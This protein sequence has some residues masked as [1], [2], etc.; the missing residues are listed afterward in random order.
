MFKKSKKRNCQ[1]FITVIGLILI[2]LLELVGSIFLFPIKETQ[3]EGWLSGYSY[4]KAITITGETGAGTNYQVKLLVGESSGAT[5][6]DFDIENNDAAWPNDIRF[7]DNDGFTQLDYWL[8]SDIDSESNRLA[9]FWVEVADDL[10]SNVDIYVYYGK[11]GDSDESNGDNTFLFFDDFPG[12]SID[13]AKW[14][15]VNNGGSITVA[16]SIVDI[17][18]SAADKDNAEIISQNAFA[19]GNMMETYAKITG[20]TNDYHQ[21]GRGSDFTTGGFG[22]EKPAVNYLYQYRYTYDEPDI[23]NRIDSMKDSAGTSSNTDIPLVTWNIIGMVSDG[24]TSQYWRDGTKIIEITDTTYVPASATTAKTFMLAFSYQYNC[25]IE[26]DWVRVRKFIAT[27]PAYS[28]A[29][30][31]EDIFYVD[32]DDLVTF[33][34]TASDSDTDTASDTVKLYVCTTDSLTSCSSGCVVSQWCNASLTGSNPYCNYTILMTDSKGANNY[35]G[36]VCDSHNFGASASISGQFYINPALRFSISDLTIGFG[37]MTTADDY[38]ATSDTNGATG[39]PASGNPTTITISTNAP[40]GVLVSARS[41]GDGTGAEGNGSAGLYKSIATTDLIAAVA[42]S[43]ITAGGTEGYGLYVKQV[44]SNLTA[45]EGF[46]NDTTSDLAISTTS[47]TILTASGEIVANNT[48]DIAL[49]AAIGGTTL[50][51]SFTDTITLIAT[52]K[53]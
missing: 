28:S 25:Q 2:M 44:G 50:A 4:R 35:Y 32:V 49:K 51:G 31:E 6:E 37:E 40:N 41:T 13:T 48:A 26:A 23:E 47:Q 27:E 9:T 29:G 5:G 43:A 36:Y 1:K 12:T 7:T 42:S 52:G 10:G 45:D 11:A 53:Y 39:E 19:F 15:T 22:E 30:A 34:A 46:D 3:A 14:Q 18:S 16:N 20:S 17:Q 21:I 38:W 24:T 8:E 33:T